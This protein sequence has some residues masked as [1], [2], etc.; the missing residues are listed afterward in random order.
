M[1]NRLS[2][3]LGS[4]ALAVLLTACA[5]KPTVEPELPPYTPAEEVLLEQIAADFHEGDYKAVIK[6]VKEAPET[7]LGGLPFRTDALKYKAFSE[8]VSKQQRNCRSTFRGLLEFNPS[9]DLTAAEANHPQWGKVFAEEK[10]RSDAAVAKAAAQQAA[11]NSAAEAAEADTTTAQLESPR[12]MPRAEIR[13]GPRQ[14]ANQ[15]E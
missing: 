1:K 13:V 12:A 8:C 2:L 5:G 4:T 6:K 14:T 15:T 10:K 11:A 9:F 3:I 7:T